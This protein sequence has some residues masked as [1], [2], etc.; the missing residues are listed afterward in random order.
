[1][2]GT[3]VSHY[4]ILEKLG[5]GG[6]GIVYKAQDLKLERLVA[7]KFLPIQ[8]LP[9]AEETARF[10]QEAKAISSLNHPHI[11][12]I[13]DID[14]ADGQKFLV[15]EYIPGSTLKSRLKDLRNY[16]RD[17][18]LAEALKYGVQVA[19]GLAHAHR[20]GIV[21]RDVKTDNIMLTEEGDAKITDFGLAKLRGTSPLTQTG[22]TLGTVAYMSP[23]QIR[24]E[25][26]DFRSDLFSFGCVLYEL[27]TGRLP[28]QGEHE[29]AI[30]YSIVNTDPP[31][32]GSV[33]PGIPPSLEAVIRRCLEK[34]KESR[35]QS[36]EEVAGELR[37]IQTG[38]APGA[39]SDSRRKLLWG[40]A[41]LVLLAGLIAVY[42]LAPF[43]HALEPSR[44][45]AVLPFI[46]MSVLH[47]RRA[48]R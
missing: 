37:R 15:L 42:L 47:R 26:V 24:G 7:L 35:F 20:H 45:I 11:A 19:E 14:E 40:A 27:V 13:H 29:A 1:M 9:S 46:N 23:E 4:R 30:T 10:H 18:P 34:K 39:K 36:A 22:S 6:M 8:A 31:P 28:F 41:A 38:L 48:T 25:E 43:K 2:V 32:A 21:H 12:A 17:F 44:S 33:R 3:T 16:G 5:E